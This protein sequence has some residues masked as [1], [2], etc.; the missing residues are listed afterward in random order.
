MY[1]WYEHGVSLK[2]WNKFKIWIYSLKQIQDKVLQLWL[3]RSWFYLS[4]LF[5]LHF[6][7][8]FQC[9]NSIIIVSDCYFEM[10]SRYGS[11]TIILP[12]LNLCMLCW[13]LSIA[14]Y[15]LDRCKVKSW[16]MNGHWLSL[17]KRMCVWCFNCVSPMHE[18]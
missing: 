5:V 13:E 14:V 9:I 12:F 4:C 7:R 1:E 11:T 2:F 8:S 6:C 16:D 10:N 18:W 17:T 3:F 15:V